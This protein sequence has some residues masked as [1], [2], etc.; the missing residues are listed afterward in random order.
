M[1]EYLFHRKAIIIP[2][3]ILHHHQKKFNKKCSR[4]Q[5]NEAKICIHVGPVASQEIH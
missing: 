3:R 2:S 5:A 1:Y 4:E